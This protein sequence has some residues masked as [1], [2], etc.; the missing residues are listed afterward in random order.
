MQLEIEREALR[1][2]KDHASRARL[3]TIEK[4]IVDLRDEVDA[5]RARYEREKAEI[6]EVRAIKEKIEERPAG[7]RAGRARLRPRAGGAAEARDDAR[8]RGA[9]RPGRDRGARA[10]DGERPAAAR[11][12]HRGGDRGDR[13]PV[14]RHPRVAAHE[15][16]REKLLHLDDVLHERVI[17]Q[18]EAV[19][20]VADAVIRSR[21]GL[22]DPRRPIG[23]F[24]FLGPTG[25]GKTELARTL[26]QALFDTRT[27]WCAST[28]RSTWSATPSRG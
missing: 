18:D 11:G 22:K 13:L 25:V 1:R 12:G 27:T 17:G 8:A 20:A 6:Q 26:A 3:D 19:R 2:E 21:S 5:L 16:E 23:S 10:T 14:D 15:G 4:E 7:A 28:C 9:A 24:L